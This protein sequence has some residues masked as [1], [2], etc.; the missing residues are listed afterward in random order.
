MTD[1][2]RALSVALM[3]ESDGPGGAELMLLQLALELRRRGHRVVPVGPAE[4]VGW[5]SARFRAE[6]FEPHAFRERPPPDFRLVRDLAHMLRALEL[7]LVHSHEFTLAVYGAAAARRLRLPH[8]VTMH[9]A[10]AR[11]TAAWRRRVALRWAF[12]RSAAAVAVSD[13][14]RRELERDLGLADRSLEVIHNG[15]SLRAG[16]P[17]PVRR[18]LGVKEGELLVLAV[19]NLEVHKGHLL[20][21]E[22]LARNAH[23]PWRLAI[24]GGRGGP[25]RPRLE[26]FAREHG[27]AERVHVLSHRDD[28]PDLQAAADVFAMPSLF[29]GLPLAL[30]EAMGAGNAIVASD[31]GGISEAVTHETHGLLVPPGDVDALAAALGR[32]L[33][34]PELRRELGE[35]AR[36]RG[37][38]EFGVEAMGGA[39]EALYRRLASPVPGTTG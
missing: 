14:T 7:D 38:R 24:A 29:E 26:A 39:Y 8:V 11:V 5:L 36:L 3:L 9:G 4:G 2:A 33:A 16:D 21:L 20:L 12:R 6:G 23:L 34:S 27:L 31:T 28:V 10:V 37:R 32:L 19:G 18:E 30:L 35:Q 25:E 13:A 15:I 17:A 22:A 1:P